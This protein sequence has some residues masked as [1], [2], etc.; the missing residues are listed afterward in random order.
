MASFRKSLARSAILHS[1]V[2]GLLLVLVRHSA[3][4]KHPEEDV[5]EVSVLGL[6]RTVTRA[7]PSVRTRRSSKE[8]L[9]SQSDESPQVSLAPLPRAIPANPGD[10]E[11]PPAGALSRR[12]C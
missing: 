5:V 7:A 10:G 9:R 6:A 3:R 11:A 8:Y 12:S 2:L 1:L 4:W